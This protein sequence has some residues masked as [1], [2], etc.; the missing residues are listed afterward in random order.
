MRTTW[1]IIL[2]LSLGACGTIDNGEKKV[3]EQKEKD[4]EKIGQA[5]S[6]H[7]NDGCFWNIAGRDTMVAWLVQTENTITGKLSFDNFQKDGSSGPVH[8]TLHGN[9][10]KLWYDFESEG[11]KSVMEVWLERRGNALV[12]AVGPM[13]VKG[14]TSYF[15]NHAAIKFD[16]KQSLQKDHRLISAGIQKKIQ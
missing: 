16:E 3:V 10:I 9:T 8:G 2:A 7:N 15:T 13:D 5:Y 14:D 11:M 6:Y 4:R 1:L 12:R